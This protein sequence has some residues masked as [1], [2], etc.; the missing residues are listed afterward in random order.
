MKLENQVV[1]LELAKRLKELGFEQNS[2][3]WWQKWVQDDWK[4]SHYREFN[5]INSKGQV[6]VS[7]FEMIKGI[8]DDTDDACSAYTVAELGEMLPIYYSTF[9]DGNTWNVDE[10]G[11][12]LD[13]VLEEL[14]AETEADAR[15]KLLIYLKENNL[16]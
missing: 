12:K 8:A 6:E 7:G 15:A 2:L 14:S 10:E 4:L 1:S 11:S 5:G 16:I 13:D 9:F 3:F